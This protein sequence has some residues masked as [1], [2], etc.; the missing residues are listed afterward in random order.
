[1]QEKQSIYNYKQ[2][3]YTSS[4]AEKKTDTETSLTSPVTRA[5][6]CEQNT[7]TYNSMKRT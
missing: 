1:M 4:E 7:P 6:E 3:V 5:V 2:L